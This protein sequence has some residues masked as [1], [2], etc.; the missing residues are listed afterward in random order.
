MP[1]TAEKFDQPDDDSGS[2]D[3]ET[4]YIKTRSGRNVK[5]AQKK[6]Q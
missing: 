3:D 1:N 2:S 5:M 4:S 6:D